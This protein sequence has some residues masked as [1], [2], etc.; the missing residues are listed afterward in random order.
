MS[1]GFIGFILI[2]PLITFSFGVLV[3]D[4]HAKKEG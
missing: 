1:I 3:G 4:Y 2:Y